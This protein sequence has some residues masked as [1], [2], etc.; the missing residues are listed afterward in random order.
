MSNLR[1]D[2][3]GNTDRLISSLKDAEARLKNFGENATR[4]G[5]ALSVGLTAPIVALGTASIVTFGRLEALQKGLIAVSGSAKEANRQFEEL[6]DVAKLPGLGLEEAVRGSVALQSAG[7]AFEQSKET[8]LAFGNALATV[9]KGKNELNFVILALTQLQNKT[10][11]FGQDLRQLTEQLPQLRGALQNAFGTSDSLEIAKLGVTGRQVVEIITK[12]FAKL[13]KVTGG[14]K[15]AFENAS[16]SIQIALAQVGESINKALDVEDLINRFAATI[17]RVADGFSNLNPTIQ[18]TILVVAGLTAALGPLLL[19]I[20]VFTTTIIPA[21]IAGLSVLK[22]AFIAATGPIGLT[23]VAVG[24]LIAGFVALERSSAAYKRTQAFTNQSLRQAGIASKEIAEAQSLVNDLVTK[25]NKLSDEEKEKLESLIKAKILDAQA[26]IAQAKAAR[27]TAMQAASQITIYD[28][29]KASLLGA[30]NVGNAVANLISIQ[31]ANIAAAAGKTN[32]EINAQEEALKSLLVQLTQVG[33]GYENLIPA[34]GIIGKLTEEIEKLTKEREQSTSK[35]EISR[36]GLLI[37]QR[38]DELKA[39]EKLGIGY[40][41]AEELAK[42][43]NKEALPDLEID[44]GT[45][46]K[47]LDEIGKNLF[48]GIDETLADQIKAQIEAAKKEM[49]RLK[50][51]EQIAKDFQS[52]FSSIIRNGIVDGLSVLAEGIGAVLGGATKIEN[53]GAQLLRSLANVLGQLGQLAIATGLA[54]AG[55]RESLKTLNPAVAIAAGVALLALAGV[56]KSQASKI[57]SNIGGGSSGFGGISN[58]VYNSVE[59]IRVNGVLTGQ[60]SELIVV[61][62]N[63]ERERGRG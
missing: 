6:R 3:I 29:I 36:L 42:K 10:T 54:V 9:G 49:A 51:I 60:G 57:G 8:L 11:G 53:V 12:E 58:N 21:A 43:F 63:A 24:A 39:I 45:E 40:K 50:E 62:E 35:A 20:G 38:E 23:V 2:I 17:S 32:E 18:K 15:N 31:Q 41:D 37:S 46:F 13:P 48:S 59:P 61:L 44:F 22:V 47:G 52:N 34:V 25:Y 30:G 4:A 26:S 27:L 1:V 7:F 19:T 5:Q 55:I 14:I 56:V 33:Q 28:K 16:D